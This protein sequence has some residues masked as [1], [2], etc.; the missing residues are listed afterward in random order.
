MTFA[1]TTGDVASLRG[2][3]PHIDGADTV[4]MTVTTRMVVESGTETDGNATTAQAYVDGASYSSPW[5]PIRDRRIRHWIR[6]SSVICW[7]RR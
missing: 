3:A 1:H 5:S 6:I 7:S 4:A 2:E